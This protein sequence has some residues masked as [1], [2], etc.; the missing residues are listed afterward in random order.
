MKYNLREKLRYLE[1]PFHYYYYHS[2]VTA[3]MS[4]YLLPCACYISCVHSNKDA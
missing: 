4:F 1:T 3:S 2:F